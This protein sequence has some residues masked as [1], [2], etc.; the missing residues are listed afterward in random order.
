MFLSNRKL[1]LK[2]LD[3]VAD[4]RRR[5]KEQ[6]RGLAEALTFGCHAENTQGAQRYVAID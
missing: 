5:E 3:L 4:R 6:F 1:C 2:L